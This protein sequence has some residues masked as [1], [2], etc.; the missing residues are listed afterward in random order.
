MIYIIR[1][2]DNRRCIIVERHTEDGVSVIWSTD[3]QG[4]C[5]NHGDD[6]ACEWLLYDAWT[7]VCRDAE[8]LVLMEPVVDDGPLLLRSS[9]LA[10]A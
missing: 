6:A 9:A 10:T 5:D 1:W 7:Q 3:G 2:S 8:Q 4:C